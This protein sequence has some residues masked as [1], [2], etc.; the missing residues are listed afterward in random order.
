M[1]TC[2]HQ[3]AHVQGLLKD[4]KGNWM[5]NMHTRRQSYAH[6]LC[7]HPCGSPGSQNRGSMSIRSRRRHS[8][9]GSESCRGAGSRLPAGAALEGAPPLEALCPLGVDHSALPAIPQ[10][11]PQAVPQ[12][13]PQ[14]AFRVPLHHL[15]T[16]PVLLLRTFG[17]HCKGPHLALHTTPK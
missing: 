15:N 12:I 13:H 7:R 1:R 6:L 11:L 10:N 8:A 14:V 17:N 3:Q 16:T 4:D 2:L 5:I 9:A